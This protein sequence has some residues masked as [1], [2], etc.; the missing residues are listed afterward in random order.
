MTTDSQL[1]S[2]HVLG[3]GKGESIVLQFPSGLWGIVDCYARSSN[4]PT[5]N[6][7][8]KFLRDSGVEKLEFLCL[9]HPHDD[10]Y[11]GMSQILREFPPRFFWHFGAQT[12]PHFIKLINYFRKEAAKTGD[13]E[14]IDDADEFVRIWLEA[15]RK[16][17]AGTTRFKESRPATQLY[18]VPL[19]PDASFQI[20]GLAPSGD[21]AREYHKAFE[22]C[23]DDQGRFRERL[24]H[25]HHNRI[26]VGL[27]IKFGT[28]RS[29]S[30]ATWRNQAGSM[31]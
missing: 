25:S 27:R 21:Q 19:D 28:T 11:R 20:W 4:D 16:R 12:P 17:E 14:A 2:I 6:P 15:D 23:T 1:L 8:L 18:P 3:A 9:T 24:P 30:A 5:T 22:T 10:H 26:S 13:Q 7:T 31:L 29:F